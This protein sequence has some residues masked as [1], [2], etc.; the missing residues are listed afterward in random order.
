MLVA[1]LSQ[2]HQVLHSR[3]HDAALSL[4]AFDQDRGRLGSSEQGL[5]TLGKEAPGLRRADLR[6]DR[7]AHGLQVVERGYSRKLAY[8]R[9]VRRVSLSALREV[10]HGDAPE[11]TYVDDSF[12]LNRLLYRPGDRGIQEF[13]IDNSHPPEWTVIGT[14]QALEAAGTKNH[15]CSNNDHACSNNDHACNVPV[16]SPGGS[17]PPQE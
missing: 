11:R 17:V 7:L 10:Y 6:S 5:D 4:D 2:A 12:T 14:W 8:L 16:G 3:R 9:Q 1:E 15:A 13:F